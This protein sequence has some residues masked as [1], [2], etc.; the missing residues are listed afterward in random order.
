MRMMLLAVLVALALDA[1]AMASAVS[2]SESF[3]D[4]YKGSGYWAGHVIV[5][6]GPAE[7]N[8]ITVALRGR[9]FVVRD[10]A[11]AAAGAGCAASGGEVACPL[12]QG[13]AYVAAVSAAGA[14]EAGGGGG[15]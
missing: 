7:A 10:G 5:D 8:D 4:G 9:A 12:R 15:R 11:G 14:D 2:Y 6:A 3:V 1:P 13:T